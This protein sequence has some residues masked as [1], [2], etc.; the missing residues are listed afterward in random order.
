MNIIAFTGAGISKS[1]GIPTFE[2]VPNIKE[3]LS[4]EFKQENPIEFSKVLNSLKESVKDKEPTKAHKVLAYFQ[5]PIITMNIDFLH[6][7][8][9]SKN[10]IEIHG[11][12]EKD[13]I[14]LYGENIHNSSD[15]IKLID[16]VSRNA[17][18]SQE[19]SIL[20]V[21]GTSLQTQFANSLILYAKSQEMLVFLINDDADIEV[22]AFLKREINNYLS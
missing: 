1:A 9:G 6:Q 2:E 19:K 17:K 7:K 8:A 20:L 10:V 22:P 15:C 16:A 14:V 5:I 4:V 11:N 3:K 12:V 13:N 21:I 18:M